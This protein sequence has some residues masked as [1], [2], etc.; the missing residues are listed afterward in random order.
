[1]CIY[2][3]KRCLSCLFTFTWTVVPEFSKAGVLLHLL[4]CL[5]ALLHTT[6]A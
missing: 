3:R 5:H 6:C 2:T 1:M 4:A